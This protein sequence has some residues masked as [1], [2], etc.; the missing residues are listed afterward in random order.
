MSDLKLQSKLQK[1]GII[2]ELLV[3][4]LIPWAQLIKILLSSDWQNVA[5]CERE[6]FLFGSG[7]FALG[8]IGHIFLRFVKNNKTSSILSKSLRIL[9]WT[10]TVINII[11]TQVM[12]SDIQDEV[13]SKTSLAFSFISI[14][15]L[16]SIQIYSLSHEMAKRI[17]VS[18]AALYYAIRVAIYARNAILPIYTFLLCVIVLA[19]L[20]WIKKY[21]KIQAE[22]EHKKDME[23]EILKSLLADAD[24]GYLILQD[25]HRV[26]YANQKA[27][28]MLDF[29][30][31][32]ISG[33]EQMKK[34]EV[35]FPEDQIN[36]KTY[37]HE[38]MS[39]KESYESLYSS[40][41]LRNLGT[42]RTRS[43]DLKRI[44]WESSNSLTNRNEPF[45]RRIEKR[46]S[47]F[48][49]IG[50]GVKG[51]VESSGTLLKS[52]SHPRMSYVTLLVNSEVSPLTTQKKTK[53]KQERGIF[54]SHTGGGLS[55]VSGLKYKLENLT[56]N[57]DTLGDQ[58]NLD[59]ATYRMN[60]E[61]KTPSPKIHSDSEQNLFG[62]GIPH[63]LNKILTLLDIDRI[64][65]L[66]LESSPLAIEQALIEMKKNMFNSTCYVMTQ[67][68]GVRLYNLK[69]YAISL[70]GET[71]LMIRLKDI[72]PL[73][74]LNYFRKSEVEKTNVLSSVS[75][76]L[77]TPLNC[78][79]TML[80]IIEKA[81]SNELKEDYVKPASH[82][83]KLLLSL[84]SDIL[85]F[86]QFRANKLRL[87]FTQFNLKKHLKD[88]LKLLSLQAKGR[89]LTLELFLDER[90]PEKV[91]SEPNRLR[92]IIINLIGNA[93]KFTM[94]GGIKL[95]VGYVAQNHYRISVKDTGIGIKPEDLKT[96]FGQFGK[97]SE[98]Q[99]INQQGVGLGLMISNTLAKLLGPNENGIRVKSQ[100]G[101]GTTFSFDLESKFALN[102]NSD[103]E[104]TP[105]DGE[106]TDRLYNN[107]ISFNE[108]SVSAQLQRCQVFQ[109]STSSLP[110]SIL[111]KKSSIMRMHTTENGENSFN[112]YQT[113]ISENRSQ[114]KE[115]KSNNLLLNIPSVIPPTKNLL[116]T[117]NTVVNSLQSF[118]ENKPIIKLSARMGSRCLLEEDEFVKKMDDKDKALFVISKRLS[119][120]NEEP[121]VLVVDDN[122]FNIIALRKILEGAN[123]KID[124]ATS[125][126]LAIQKILEKKEKGTKKN[127]NYKM[128]FM[129]CNMP[130]KD[131]YKTTQEIRDLEAKGDIPKIPIIAVTAAT[132]PHE[133]QKCFDAGMD[134]YLSKPVNFKALK[135]IM[136]K[137]M[138]DSDSP[139]CS[140]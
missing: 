80:D 9:T 122:A 16:G 106:A 44:T 61:A 136:T 29:S 90:I 40:K 130:I 12:V 87:S 128:I 18:L 3:L 76:E 134:D 104:H 126:D 66:T 98:T 20:C 63:S 64:P 132:Y 6:F 33:L 23:I 108:K 91:C 120:E 51:T 99:N 4:L 38:Q 26:H 73:E 34:F 19:F 17:M 54:K 115:T 81:V 37:I 49:P 131:G 52:K 41:K 137:F 79:I 97:V 92:Q 82:S 58:G 57:S 105:S 62:E 75:H 8:C 89:G 111:S 93:L 2:S 28:D 88:I 78:I 77:R 21:H 45:V 72:A 84:I 127:D 112:Y 121:Q 15:A 65:L 114:L 25:D 124:S 36:L 139:L 22:N 24:E 103:C 27:Y 123:F 60:E 100:Y 113:Q 135:E 94:S 31:D 110:K 83:A 35:L 43:D 96:L 125:G 67:D 116:P 11:E 10:F 56:N 69:A 7:I 5:S 74:C 107:M 59:T 48:K 119:V 102:M 118:D 1:A 71:N 53:G 86:S 13:R 46:D 50:K 70:D 140:P 47:R 117:G 55:G 32:L 68:E 30:S 133:I 42:M 39:A 109:K 101:V 14:C 138:K 129:D 95:K 85:D